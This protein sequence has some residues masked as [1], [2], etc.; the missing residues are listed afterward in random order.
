MTGP[1][2]LVTGAARGIGAAT[3][4]RLAQRGLHVIAVD[5]CLGAEQGRFAGAV[6]ADLAMLQAELGDSVTTVRADVRDARG[7]A[8]GIADALAAADGLRTVAAAAALIDGGDDLWSTDPAVL[9]AMWRTD[10]VG[11]WNTA[12]SCVPALLAT[13]DGGGDASFVAIASAAGDRGLWH[14]A[15]YCTVKHAVVGLVRGLAADLQG[16]GVAVSAVSPGSTATPMLTATAAIYGLTDTSELA[17]EMTARVPLAPDDIAQV[18]ET[19]CLAGPVTH[20]SI[21]DATGGFGA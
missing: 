20:G 6:P 11:V 16:R 12:A 18:I 2:A 15:A 1:A 8:A 19:A 14:L 3:C 5:A 4:R 13:A 17:R 7:L 10:V 9:E 21:F